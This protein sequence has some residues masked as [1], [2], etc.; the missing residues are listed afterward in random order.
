MILELSVVVPVYKEE[1]NISEFLQRIV[2][3]LNGSLNDFEIIFVLD[4]SPDRTEE[5]ILAHHVED[6]RIKL[7]K[8]SRRFGQPMA[9]L[10]GLSRS[11][12]LAVAVIDLGLGVPPEVIAQM[13][14]N[15]K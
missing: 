14:L 8:L 11:S 4:P 3:I 10:A 6:K 9:I 2:P 7:V 13:G 12:G 1:D 15:W 5:I